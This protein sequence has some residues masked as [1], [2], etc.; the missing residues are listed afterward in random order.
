MERVGRRPERIGIVGGTFDPPHYAHLILA[1]H[2][3]E[4]LDLDRV[5][6]VPA[7][8]PPHKDSTRTPVEHRLA[9]LRLATADNPAF[10]ISRVDIDRSPPHYSVDMVRILRDQ[11]PAARLYFI[12]GEDSFRDL[13][14]W[15][16]PLAMV[17]HEVVQ[18]AVMCRP[19][20]DDGEPTTAP[21]MHEAVLPGLAQ[22]VTMLASRMVEISS[23][24]IVRRL[25]EGKSV[26]YLLPEAVLTYIVE[27]HLYRLKSEIIE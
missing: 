16:N 15:K 14:T 20:I 7:G 8:Q 13:P 24:D 21:A 22:H 25:K 1:E 19:G 2:A 3:R 6:F 26:H 11:Y 4:E 27:H 9:M 23:T 12:M 18:L 5:L 17:E 10:E